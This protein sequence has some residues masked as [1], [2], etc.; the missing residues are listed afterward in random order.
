MLEELST[1]WR[2]ESEKLLPKSEALDGQRL[3]WLALINICEKSVIKV[4]SVKDG[5]E[6]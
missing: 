4:R 1:R 5:G 2:I 6:S 3:F